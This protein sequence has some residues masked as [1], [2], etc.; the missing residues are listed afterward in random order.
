VDNLT[1]KTDRDGRVIQYGYDA[2]NRP[3]TE[4]WVSSSPANTVT[5]TYDAAGRETG[6]QDANS[7][8]AFG[9]DNA[10]RLTSVD[11]QGTT[12]V[13][14]VILTYTYDNAGNRTGLDDSLGGLTS[15][16]YDVRNELTS[17]TQSGT[18][19]TAKRADFGYDAAG[20]MTSQTRYSNL[21]GTTTVL[22]TA[23]AYAGAD[24]LT[25]IT[26]ETALTGG[27]VRA[28]FGYTLDNANRLTSE[29]RTWASGASSDSV[30]YSYT[31]N[32]QLTGVTHTNSS[33]A[34]ESFSYD[35]NGNRNSTGYSTGTGNRLSSDGTY[36]YG[37]DDEGNQTS[38]TKISDGSQTV[39]KWDYRNRLTEVDS[40]V[41]GVTTVLA[42]YTYDAL[43]RRIGVAES[44]ASTW[45]VFDGVSPI[46]DFN[47]SGT[48]TARYLNG[49]AVDELLARETSGGTVAWYLQDRLGTVRDIVDNTGALIDHIDY[50][51]FG[52]VLSESSS[53][54]GD[55]FKFA[56][57]QYDAVVGSYCDNARWYDP[58]LG[59]FVSPD[60]MRFTAGDADLYR[61][62]GN[63]ASDQID[64]T[65]FADPLVPIRLPIRDPTK[66]VYLNGPPHLI[67][68]PIGYTGKPVIEP[69][70]NHVPDFAR[71]TVC[72]PP[73][74]G[75]FGI[76]PS[77]VRDFNEFQGPGGLY[78][79]INGLLANYRNGV[80]DDLDVVLAVH[81][82]P[83]LLVIGE[84]PNR[85][86][87]T[88]E[89]DSPTLPDL[90]SFLRPLLA[91]PNS[92]LIIVGCNVAGNPDG[93]GRD[94]GNALLTRLRTG[95]G[96]P[97]IAPT[98]STGLGKKTPGL[99]ISPGGGFVTY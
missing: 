27:T 67:P 26:H 12:G 49:P 75:G 24:R 90:I 73:G 2:D 6:V 93:T 60:P 78:G 53:V 88:V 86:P 17:L 71:K 76:D 54:N 64:P 80:P 95:L 16:S 10:N 9:Y 11:N 32:D 94:R 48:Q 5:M 21:A 19:V 1:Q 79:A 56:G 55:R 83:G 61:Y 8:Y 77:H 62:V 57:M 4:T 82:A 84:S 52:N 43:D 20:R 96:R 36:N 7:H 50:G 74:Q 14:H 72:A 87:T 44:G 91:G 59:R 18:G 40:V 45:T 69:G 30:S 39:Y 46:L 99:F 85:K 97:V 22:V 42:T 35:A 68:R 15:Y 3:T 41:S 29:S 70:D 58:R 89:P 63:G 66:T 34:S 81:G 13:P 51:V 92:R 28:S 31:N 47:G 25:S 65:G 37:Y 33:F 23:Y 98:G 38:R